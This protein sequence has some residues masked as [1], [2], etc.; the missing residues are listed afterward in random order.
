[1][2]ACSQTRR[3]NPSGVIPTAVVFIATYLTLMNSISHAATPTIDLKRAV[4]AFVQTIPGAGQGGYKDPTSDLKA[5]SILVDGFQ[6][7]RDGQLSAARKQLALVSYRALFYVDS[8]TRRELIL[9][10]EQRVGGAYPRAWGLYVIASPLK[11]KLSNLIVEVPHACPRATSACDG[12]DSDSHLVGVEA[13]RSGNARYLFINGA[14]R[15]ATSLSDVAHE[16]ESPFEKIHEAALNP[17]QMGLGA[18][19]KVYQSHRFFSGKHDGKKGDPPAPIDNVAPGEGAVANVV[20]SNGT[21][22]VNG[23]LAQKVAAAVEAK[24]PRFFFV[25]LATGADTCSDLAATTNVQ[26]DHMYGGSFVHVEVNES[27][28]VCDKPCRR[29][30]LAQAVAGAMK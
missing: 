2:K 24:D 8:V 18:K 28:Y 19:A 10:A 22:A 9:L 1:M 15:N 14:Q 23:T 7:A 26:K 17:K 21:N 3:F 29:D 5:R 6:K 20:V 25:C 27:I 11:Q 4:D 30:Q 13:F 12:G 16:P